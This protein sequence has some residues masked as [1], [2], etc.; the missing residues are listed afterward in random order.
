MLGLASFALAVLRPFSDWPQTNVLNGGVVG[1]VLYGALIP[2]VTAAVGLELQWIGL[3]AAALTFAGLY[4]ALGGSV[5]VGSKTGPAEKRHRTLFKWGG[6]RAGPGKFDSLG[7]GSGSSE[8]S[9][10]SQP[11]TFDATAPRRGK[12]AEKRGKSGGHT[13]AD[14]GPV[15]K[16]RLPSIK[17]LK[18]Y[19]AGRKK[20]ASQREEIA[21]NARLLESVLADFGVKGRVVETR[22]GPVVTLYEFEPAPG[23]KSSQMVGLAED[24]ARSLS[25]VFGARRRC[26][27]TQHHGHRDSE[28]GSRFGAASR[29]AGIGG[30]CP[31]PGRPD[32]GPWPGHRRRPGSGGLG[33]HAPPPGR[34]HHRVRQVGGD[35]HDDPVAAFPAHSQSMP[36]HHDRPEDA[37]ADGL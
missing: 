12:V 34:R 8:Q 20:S 24:I 4:L 1:D 15:K 16:Y 35:Q 9:R 18:A 14:L 10:E 23:V 11:V 3:L 21:R 33:H 19:P 17:L 32:S 36:F 26:F 28:Q 25:A 31:G 6:L 2:E 30:L 7:T 29:A 27:R 37:G 13:G 5:T 22:P